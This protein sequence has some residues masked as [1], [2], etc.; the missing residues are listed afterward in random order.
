M[1]SVVP[2]DIVYLALWEQRLG[3]IVLE[4]SKH[5][6]LQS[7]SDEPPSKG[8]RDGCNG[9]QKTLVALVWMVMMVERRISENRRIM[10]KGRSESYVSALNY[11]IITSRSSCSV[12]TN[13]FHWSQTVSSLCMF[14]LLHCPSVS[15]YSR[16]DVCSYMSEEYLCTLNRVNHI[17]ILTKKQ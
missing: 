2:E 11:S 4:W 3:Q 9:P 13:S 6:E 7:H 1:I 17:Q 16:L 8:K 15:L 10:E 5:C 12:T 14:P